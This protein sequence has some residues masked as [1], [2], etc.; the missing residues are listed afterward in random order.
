M[1]RLLLLSFLVLA[2]G[3]QDQVQINTPYVATPSPVVDAMLDLAHVKS[4]DLIYDL[5]CG[6]GRIV[7]QAAKRYGARGI[8]VDNNPER[9]RE[10][11][12]NARRE[13]VGQLVEFRLG[14]L[15]DTNV[16]NATI[17]AL[18]LLPDVNLRLRPKLKAQLKPGA[19][20][21]SHTFDMGDWKPKKKR[22]VNGEKIYLWTIKRRFWFFA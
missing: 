10:A 14:D 12:E 4:S 13:G 3:A 20:V 5:G 7:I 6:D 17:V 2:L 1:I 22:I 15:Y 11:Q 16:E 18:Y 21:V 8:G 19:R 9:I